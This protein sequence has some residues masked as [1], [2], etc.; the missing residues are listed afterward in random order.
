MLPMQTKSTFI[1]SILNKTCK[2]TVM[3]HIVTP[4]FEKMGSVS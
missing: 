2:L 3:A 1:F 4:E